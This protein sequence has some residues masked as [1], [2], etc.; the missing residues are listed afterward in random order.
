M[1]NTLFG[2]RS[3]LR[4]QRVKTQMALLLAGLALHAAQV[5]AAANPALPPVLIGFD[6]AY[7]QKTNTAP[8]AI[9]L[10]ARAAIDEIN[11]A[12]G[13][14]GG[15]PLQLVTTD[16]KGVSARGKDN[17][18]EL[19]SMKDMVA[20]LGGKYSPISVEVLPEAQRL[21]V[22][23]ISVWGSADA[24]TEQKARP[25]YA[26]RVSLKDEWGVQAMIARL[27]RKHKAARACAF[28]P[29]TAWGRSAEQVIKTH[30]A[31]YRV[32]FSVVRWYNWGD[33]TLVEAY[34]ACLQAKTQALLFVGNEKEAAVLLKDM[35]NL[36]AAQ[37]L[38][39]VA[40]WGTVGGTLHELVGSAL[41]QISFDVIQT[42]TFVNN[43]R[44]RARQLADWIAQHSPYKSVAAIPSPVGAAHAYDTVHLLAL[45]VAR[46]QSAQASQ[47]RD[48]LEQLPH[49][50]GAVRDYKP[51]FTAQRHDALSAEQVLFVRLTPEGVLQPVP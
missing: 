36:P 6:G 32:Q 25:S 21:K 33:Q 2:A 14:L 42:F 47:V 23:L 31:K 11:R 35:V 27:A 38:P 19:A 16:N 43:P 50:S 7:G 3:L 9:E 20:V 5:Q 49:F 24:I 46:A 4:A 10:G 26:F 28:L 12:G 34:Q 45:A 48:A 40:H 44:P 1:Q 22:P 37:R 41:D 30:A 39:V 17:F 18:I 51:A 15:R 13:V 29:N 8:I